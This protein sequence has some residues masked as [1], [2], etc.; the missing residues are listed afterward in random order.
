MDNQ[1]VLSNI[2]TD[3]DLLQELLDNLIPAHIEL[4]PKIF[5]FEHLNH[6][7]EKIF[8]TNSQR[9]KHVISVFSIN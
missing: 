2:Q 8:L 3:N 1:K 6:F 9:R 4:E 7:F 5:I